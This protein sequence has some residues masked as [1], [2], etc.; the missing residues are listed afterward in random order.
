MI[1][2]NIYSFVFGALLGSFLNV[3]IYRIPKEE[4]F[5]FT[6]SYCPKCKKKIQ[7][8]ENIPML[9]FIFL[10]GKCSKCKSKISLKYFFVELATAMASL[11][12][13]PKEITH[14]T[15]ALY[16]F[17]L[18]IFCVFI[19]H[20]FIDLKYKI[21]P[22]SLNFYLACLFLV[23]GILFFSWKHWLLGGLVGLC[24]PL[25]ITW[26]FYLVRGKIGLG[27]GDIKLYAALGLYLGPMGILQN[28]FL[29]CFMGSIIGIGLIL[30]KVIK[31]D[32]PIPFGPFI[33][34]ISFVQI[35]FPKVLFYLSE[36]VPSIIF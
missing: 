27:G 35:F 3:L 22:D 36:I 2:I 17:F 18:S 23:Y 16:G 20:F 11:Y 4:D 33:I 13:F 1:L 19:V 12:L 28:I 8:F 5:V 7:W 25:L 14:Y 31:R 9:S 10:K 32:Y 15:L 24:F 26:L 29:S 6:R 34:I 21:L 30:F